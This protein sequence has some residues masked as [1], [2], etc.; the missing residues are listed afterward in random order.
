MNFRDQW[1][2]H[3]PPYHPVFMD[4]WSPDYTVMDEAETSIE[5]KPNRDSH[6]DTH[7]NN[8]YFDYE[9]PVS[10]LNRL[11]FDKRGGEGVPHREEREPK[12]NMMPPP[13]NREPHPRDMGARSDISVDS[14]ER[15]GHDQEAWLAD[16]QARGANIVQV[17]YPRTANND[18]ELTVVRGEYL[19]VSYKCLFSP[20]IVTC[21][22]TPLCDSYNFKQQ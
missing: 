4:G 3:V 19:E 21:V 18:K 15:T 20:K 10:E 13:P 2:G 5:L 7:Y 1:K 8:D 11:I 14:I 9:Q 17:T 16:L 6:E 22:A 12:M